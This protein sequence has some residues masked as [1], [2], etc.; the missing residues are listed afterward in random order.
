MPQIA[1]PKVKAAQEKL[2]MEAV[3]APE[4]EVKEVAAGSAVTAESAP[5]ESLP[6]IAEPKE[7]QVIVAAIV[8]L[9]A[10]EERRLIERRL[11]VAERQHQAEL[12]KI[13]HG[14]ELAKI[15]HEAQ[16]PQPTDAQEIAAVFR[17]GA[18]EYRRIILDWRQHVAKLHS[19]RRTVATLSKRY[20]DD[21]KT[22][23]GR[24]V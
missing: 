1:E 12:A 3:A 16:I 20:H 7:V 13:W 11:I 15:W 23:P 22:D 14:A 5:E 2:C 19:H 21:P 9:G 4:P 6:Q 8:Q 10:V 18:M 17:F 24:F